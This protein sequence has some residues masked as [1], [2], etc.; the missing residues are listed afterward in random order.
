M[1][2]PHLP[3]PRMSYANVTATLA[4]VIATSTGGAYAAA[5]IGSSQI[6]DNAIRSRHIAKGAV[7]TSELHSG[8]VTTHKIRK[9]AVGQLRL[10]HDVA[11]AKAYGTIWYP[12]TSVTN[13]RNLSVAN[14]NHPAT[15]IYCL[16]GLNFTPTLAVASSTNEWNAGRSD[17]SVWNADGSQTMN[18]P[19][20]TQLEVRLYT[21]GGSTLVDSN[22]SIVIY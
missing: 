6:K 12:G 20:G 7:K 3:R 10:G 14:V 22:F 16:S 5:T 2:L 19:T 15:G 9:H 4:L 21:I 11:A 1:R 18:C 17:V 13:S 8:S